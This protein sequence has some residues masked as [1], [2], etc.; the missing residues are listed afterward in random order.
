MN[1]PPCIISLYPLAWED[2]S[3][4]L[5]TGVC[6]GFTTI[7]NVAWHHFLAHGA[8]SAWICFFCAHAHFLLVTYPCPSLGLCYYSSSPIKTKQL[9]GKSSDK[10]WSKRLREEFLCD[11]ISSYS[12]HVFVGVNKKKMRQFWWKTDAG[13]LL[14]FSSVTSVSPGQIGCVCLSAFLCYRWE[15]PNWGFFVFFLYLH[16]NANTNQCCQRTSKKETHCIF[17][18]TLNIN[19]T[20]QEMEVAATRTAGWRELSK[21]LH[22]DPPGGC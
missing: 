2:V 20:H 16:T 13:Y 11:Y 15:S 7:T 3:N 21:Q 22:A 14:L 17:Q 8:K 5:P 4:N 18:L 9:S 6:L 10:R 12:A 19:S 1:M